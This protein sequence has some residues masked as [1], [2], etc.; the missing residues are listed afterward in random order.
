MELLVP[1]LTSV[2]VGAF[3]GL[4]SSF[5]L[6]ALLIELSLRLTFS[7]VTRGIAQSSTSA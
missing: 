4:F 5:C 1:R 2:M 3:A 6:N 7:T